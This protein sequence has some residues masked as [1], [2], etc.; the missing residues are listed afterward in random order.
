M[1]CG[2]KFVT[3]EHI[4]SRTANKLR[5]MVEIIMELYSRGSIIV[6][7]IEMDL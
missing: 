3:L 2:I 1:S 6:Q 4:P 5:K 7:T